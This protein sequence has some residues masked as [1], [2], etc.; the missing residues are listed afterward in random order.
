MR[1]QEA[2]LEAARTPESP[3]RVSPGSIQLGMHGLQPIHA[4]VSKEWMLS[5]RPYCHFANGIAMLSEP[6]AKDRHSPL[7]SFS[8]R[9]SR[10]PSDI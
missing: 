5:P 3:K 4:Y 6:A 7:Q 2:T 10:R 9:R 1:I 8:R